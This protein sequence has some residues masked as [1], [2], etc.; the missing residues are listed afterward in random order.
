MTDISTIKRELTARAEAVCRDLLPAGKKAGDEF[1]VGSVSGEAGDSLKVRLTGPKAGVWSDFATNEGGDLLDLWRH[2]HGVSLAEALEQARGYLGIA[3]RPEF[4]KQ[5]TRI[6]TR[7]KQP[8]GTSAPID[9]RVMDY[10]REERNLPGSVLEAY[11]IRACDGDIV[12]PFFAENELRMVK[13]RK[14]WEGHKPKPTEANCEP[15]LFGWQAIPET[16]RDVVITEGEIDALSI[17]AY[18]WPALSVPFGGGG[19]QKQQWVANDWVRLERF[20]T[21]YLAMDM[22]AA[23][24]AAVDEL[25]TRLG[26]H[27]CRVVS[28][29]RKDANECLMD[30]VS[31]ADIDAAMAD[32][33]W[34]EPE[35]LQGAWTYVDALVRKRFPKPGDHIG[36]RLPY[37]SAGDKVL[38]RPSEVTV[39]TGA[40]GSG[41]SQ[42]LGDCTVDWI[43]QGSRICLAS[44]EMP[45]PKT[46]KRMVKQATNTDRPTRDYLRQAVRWLGSG[47]LIYERVGEASL[48]N[49]LDV[50]DY[51][52]RRYGCDQFII[53]SLMCLGIKTD[54]YNSQERTMFRVDEWAVDRRCH[55]HFVAH[56]RKSEKG[57]G[58][59][60]IEDIKGAMEIGAYAFN[61]ISVW[62]NRDWED[63]WA[64][65]KSD[66]EREIVEEKPGVILNCCKQRHG[67]WEGKIGLW[68]NRET[69]QYR[70]SLCDRWGRSYVSWE[71]TAT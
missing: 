20:E 2:V 41:K 34:R 35:A 54:D 3:E 50:W 64:M 13:V 29:P 8:S 27:R 61:V 47:L 68:F 37:A 44:L 40:S 17:A 65:A 28:L 42:I 70:S 66:A 26:A 43:K 7:P 55:V 36:Y 22:D 10:L 33:M 39:W 69:Y 25:V 63:R 58:P 51:A 38:F 57:Q 9:N 21:I 18:G 32:A 24:I 31:K 59:Q 67:D 5:P 52:R 11:K 4:H 49:L 19:G 60:G 15:V 46:L 1:Q 6:W 14:A 56:S 30:G 71:Q 53:D 16:A 45:P 48:D 12:F 62:R 23:G